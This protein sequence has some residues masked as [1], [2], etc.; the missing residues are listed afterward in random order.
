M[1]KL[2]DNRKIIILNHINEYYEQHN[3]TPAVRD[4][5]ASTG[6]P[7]TSVQRYLV[8]LKESG[9]LDYNCRRSI[10]TT[11]IKK[12]YEHFTVP[13]LGSVACGPGDYEEENIVEYI[14]IPVSQLRKGDYFALIAKGHSMVDIG[15]DEGD[16]VIV[17]KQNTAKV[18]DI[19]VAL[20]DGGL[21]NLKKLCYDEDRQRY[22]LYSCNADQETYAPI[23]V[24]ELQV[25][26]VAV[27]VMHNLEQE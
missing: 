2:D 6:I 10:G 21:N 8:A 27:R 3:R 14:R 16:C 1:P 19:V 26:G 25:Q 15:V 23:Y 7:V 12:E 17:R 24:D 9:A 13:I 18:G 22:Y 4:I 11:R 5:S 20:Y